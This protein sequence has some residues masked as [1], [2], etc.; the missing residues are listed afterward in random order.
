MYLSETLRS[1]GHLE[2]PSTFATTGFAA[3]MS[4]SMDL[5][6]WTWPL[7]FNVPVWAAFCLC[8]TRFTEAG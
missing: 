1:L 6:M 4:L 7:G 8:G 3:Q 2:K 5:V